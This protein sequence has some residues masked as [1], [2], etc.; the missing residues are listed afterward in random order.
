MLVKGCMLAS[1]DILRLILVQE[2]W[3]RTICNAVDLSGPCQVAYIDT[4]FFNNT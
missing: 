3:P 1:V 2:V 4:I